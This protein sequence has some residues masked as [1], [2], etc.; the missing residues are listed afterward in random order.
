MSFRVIARP[1]SLLD[2]ERCM[3]ASDFRYERPQ[4]LDEALALMCDNG[5]EAMVLAGGQS[6]MPMMNFRMAE[7]GLLVDLNEIEA[8]KG[9]RLDGD[10]VIIGAMTRY[11]E[12]Q[13]SQ[14][15]AQHIPLMAMALPHIAHA[16]IRNRGTIGGSVSLADPAAEMPALLMVLDARIKVLGQSG[17]KIIS[18]DD[19]FLG[20]YETA[21]E[22]GEL[23]TEILVPKARPDQRFGFY[24]LARRHG[25]YAMSGVAVVVRGD[26]D[27]ESCRI[28]F[29]AVSDKSVRAAGAEA[30]MTGSRSDDAASIDKA[31]AS[32]GEIDFMGDLNARPETKKHLS[33]VV[34]RRA[35]AEL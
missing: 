22:E 18:A 4:S 26:T 28:A 14:D 2:G 1:G 5:D 12:L 35:L 3:K 8:L 10:D 19:F 20:I 29:F 30:V 25:D 15:V 31:V 13:A 11:A 17:E 24:E 16:A 32:L 6:L 9:I 7:P 27:I 33:G 23:V 34:L 21:L